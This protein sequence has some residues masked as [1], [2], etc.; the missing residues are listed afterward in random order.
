VTFEDTLSAS[1]ITEQQVRNLRSELKERDRQVEELTRL[2][3]FYDTGRKTRITVPE[4][5]RPKRRTPK[6][7]GI[8]VAQL[9]DWHLDEVVVPEQILGLNA[10]NR[11]IAHQRIERWV[12]KVITLPREYMAGLNI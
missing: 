12:E 5:R 4:W 7:A 1:S 11:A 2:A 10:Y 3:N 9:T 8:Q 6:K